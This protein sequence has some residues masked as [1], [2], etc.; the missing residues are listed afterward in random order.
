MRHGHCSSNRF[1]QLWK[2]VTL[3]RRLAYAK[4]IMRER[5][6]IRRKDVEQTSKFA[7]SLIC[8]NGFNNLWCSFE[9]A[10]PY[11]NYGIVNR[12]LILELDTKDSVKITMGIL[13]LRIIGMFSKEFLTR[14]DADKFCRV[15]MPPIFRTRIKPKFFNLSNVSGEGCP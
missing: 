4:L 10:C 11:K 3:H 14:L 13:A 6:K 9:V 2:E 12:R 1:Q 5:S 15:N 7:A 8:F